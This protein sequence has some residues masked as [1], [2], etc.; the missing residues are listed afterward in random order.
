MGHI[1]DTSQAKSSFDLITY[2][3]GCGFLKQLLYLIGEKNLMSALKD[4]FSNNLWGNTSFPH[5]MKSLNKFTNRSN[6]FI[7]LE[8]FM[9][10]WLTNRGVNIIQIV[11]DVDENNIIKR[12]EIHQ[13]NLSET[14]YYQIYLIDIMAIFENNN[15][16]LENILILNDKITYL[17]DF[18]GKKPANAYLPNFNDWGYVL[19][20]YDEKTLEYMENTTFQF[21]KEYQ[22]VNYLSNIRSV[23]INKK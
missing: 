17:N 15:E 7:D 14:I 4:Y 8:K 10:T 22:R 16:L 13:T 19:V 21:S 11:Y 9:M 1:F 18:V 12:F 5:L 20:R 6:N 3:K 2:N 23:I